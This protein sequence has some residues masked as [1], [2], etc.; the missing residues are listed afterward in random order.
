MAKFVCVSGMN[1]ADEFAIMPGENLVGRGKDCQVVLF[2]KRASRSHCRIFREGNYVAIEDLGSRNGTFL[3][4]KPLTKKAILRVGDRIGIGNTLLEYS[5]K[6][7]GGVLEQTLTDAAADLQEKRYDKL[8][9]SASADVTNKA[10][11]SPGTD[12]VT[13]N[14]GALSGFFR[15]LFGS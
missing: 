8:M 2:D 12:T 3:N 7:L 9:S 14:R 13:I 6:G 11:H 5:D 1:R 10:R 15:K 4:G